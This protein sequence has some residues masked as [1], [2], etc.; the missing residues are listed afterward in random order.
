[1]TVALTTFE[2]TEVL[3]LTTECEVTALTLPVVSGSTLLLL[4]VAITFTAPR[5]FTAPP[6]WPGLLEPTC[7]V[8]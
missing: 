6:S 3:E 5:V 2:E 7:P 8:E 4:V 1:M